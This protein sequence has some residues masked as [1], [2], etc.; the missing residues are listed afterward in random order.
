MIRYKL[1]THYQ[2]YIPDKEGI[3]AFVA[4]NAMVFKDSSFIEHWFVTDCTLSLGSLLLSN[5]RMGYVSTNHLCKSITT[6]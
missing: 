3:L 2:L 4:S 5:N 6:Q 1:V